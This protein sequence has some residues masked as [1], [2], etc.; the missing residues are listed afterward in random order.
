MRSSLRSRGA[1]LPQPRTP[2]RKSDPSTPQPW[3]V[4]GRPEKKD[5]KPPM[6]PR[7][8]RI[9]TFI[10]VALALNLILSAV[11]SRPEERMS[12]PYTFFRTQ[13]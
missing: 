10:I 11:L 8:R 12:V 9:W 7:S 13:V 1:P 4:E 3:R 6:V 5:D 2:E